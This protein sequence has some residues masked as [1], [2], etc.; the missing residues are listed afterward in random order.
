MDKNNDTSHLADPFERILPS[1]AIYLHTV[2]KQYE[3]NGK[4]YKIKI[5]N[6]YRKKIYSVIFEGIQTDWYGGLSKFYIKTINT[7][8][9]KFFTWLNRIDINQ[10]N[11][12]SVLKE[13]ES[14]Q[15]NACNLKPQSAGINHIINLMDKGCDSL[16]IDDNTLVYIDILSKNT[17]LSPPQPVVQDTLSNFFGSITWLKESLGDKDWFKLESPKRLINSFSISIATILIFIIEQKKIARELLGEEFIIKSGKTK[18]LK[19]FKLKQY[20]REIYLNLCEFDSNGNPITPLTHLVMLDIVYSNKLEI[21]K[22]EFILKKRDWRNERQVKVGRTNVFSLPDLFAATAWDCPSKFEQVL[23][24]WLCAWMTIQPFDIPKLKLNNFVISKNMKGRCIGIQCNYYK[25]RSGRKLQPFMLNTKH[26]ESQAILAYLQQFKG[27]E[28]SLFPKKFQRTNNLTFGKCSVTERLALMLA[29]QPINKV[30]NTN[31]KDRG[32]SSIFLRAYE[33][34][35]QKKEFEFHAWFNARRRQNIANASY[36]DYQSESK[37]PLPSILF[38][39]SHIKTSSIHSRT[40]TYRD[41]DLINQ[42]SHSP[43]VEKTSYLTDSNKMWVNQYQRITRIVLDDI[44]KHAYK[45]NLEQVASTA[46]DLILRTLVIN[47]ANLSSK[48]SSKWLL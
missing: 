11:R 37:Y 28:S 35:Y 47:A 13:F 23:F 10:S 12:Y 7:I 1:R 8:L 38:G 27:A 21:F 33:A 41:G 29:L 19:K 16:H 26:V 15:I 44:E 17:S 3:I 31:L 30:I 34:L 22:N 42:N 2:P 18:G 43:G 25:G 45:P 6:I 9:A 5:D 48:G 46:N 36:P 4:T 32:T 40:D 24:S 20:C 14:F 39:L